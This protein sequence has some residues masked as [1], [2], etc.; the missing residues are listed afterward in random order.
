MM[1]LVVGTKA[2]AAVLGPRKV[3]KTHLVVAKT[4]LVVAMMHLVVAMM[5]LVVGTKA[6]AAVLGPRKVAKT[7]LVVGTKARA[8]VLG[9][10]KVATMPL[11]A[12]TAMIVVPVL[13]L[14]EMAMI[15]ERVLPTEEIVMTVV[16][17]PQLA[18]MAMIA[19]RVPHPSE[20]VTRLQEVV[21]M[22]HAPT[23]LVMSEVQTKDVLVV[24]RKAFVKAVQT[25][26]VPGLQQ[27]VKKQRVA[28]MAAILVVQLQAET[29]MNPL[30]PKPGMN[31]LAPKPGMKAHHA[32]GLFVRMHPVPEAAM[33][34]KVN[35]VVP[36]QVV[37]QVLAL[38]VALQA[39]AMVVP[40]P[41]ASLSAGNLAAR[42]SVAREP[43]AVSVVA[44]LNTRRSRG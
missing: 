10:R 9:P 27:A 43:L 4:P 7:P 18:E 15:A 29:G 13:Q 31:P 8:A 23:S 30:A 32:L 40:N 26:V 14:V 17:V 42:V 11:P 6:K 25:P 41:V 36:V 12:E 5:H 33:R 37:A 2:K 34:P 38:A 24:R 35:H 21:A 28:V 1:H 39:K 3:A 19:E 44:V 22:I 16:R 20:I